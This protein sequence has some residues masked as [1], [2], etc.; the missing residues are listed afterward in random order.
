MDTAAVAQV[1]ALI[2]DLGEPPLVPDET[3]WT[4]L[5]LNGYA[6]GLGKSAVFRS[7]ADALEA[8]AVSEVLIAKKITTQDLSTDGPAVARELR[9]LAAQFRRRADDEDTRSRGGF[10]VIDSGGGFRNEAEEWRF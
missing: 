8:I 2:A 9:E 4:Y 6:V 7:A 5:E 10:D 1:R 3:L